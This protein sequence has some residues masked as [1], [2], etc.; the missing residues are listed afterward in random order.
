MKITTEN[1]LK[2]AWL[3]L[4]R[5]C[6]MRCKWCYAASTGYVA[7]S[8]MK[9]ELAK[10]LVLLVREVGVKSIILIGGEPTLWKPLFEFNDFCR[11]L[12]IKT[13]LVT[14]G[15]QFRSKE[16]IEE[17]Q[18][19]PTTVVA[20]SLKAFDESSSLAITSISDFEGVKEGMRNICS[21]SK[22]YISIV[23]NT[24]IQ[25]KLVEMVKTATE[26]GS[27]GV[28][29][30]VCTPMSENGKFVSPFTVD[31]DIMVDEISGS[32]EKMME[33][34]KG[35]LSL[36]LK[37]PFCIWPRDF[38]DNLI[39]L[40]QVG[41]GCQFFHR[42]GV[43]FDTDGTAML[44]NSMFDCPVGKFETNFSDGESLLK[45]LDSN[46]V[47]SIYRHITAYPSKICVDCDLYVRCRGGCPIMWTT[48]NAE[49]IISAAKKQQTKK[50]D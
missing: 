14:N 35:N 22:T 5:A 17:F 18:Q 29:V 12:N 39:R 31:Y 1:T 2:G 28:R 21:I 15:R 45:L 37:T 6:D 48:R 23:Y 4:N 10:K 30:S 43:I 46:E 33:L 44:C 16:F 13:S 19:H 26:L 3:T 40:N 41:S 32:Y 7:G 34:T 27:F 36:E 50:G 47:K 20:P 25:G 38:I 8:D 49:E 42:A 11:D 24:L 9:L